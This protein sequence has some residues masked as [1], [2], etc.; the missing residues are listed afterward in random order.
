MPFL[1]GD[2]GEDTLKCKGSAKVFQLVCSSTKGYLASAL[3]FPF[4]CIVV[5]VSYA[6]KKKAQKELSASYKVLMQLEPHTT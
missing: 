4:H 3:N 2:T 5:L 6:V 1:K